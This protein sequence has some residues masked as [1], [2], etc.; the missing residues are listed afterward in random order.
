MRALAHIG[1][2]KVLEQAQ[3]PL[4]CIAGTSMGGLI[5]AAWATGWS[6]ERLEAEA[7]HLA[8][9]RRLATLADPALGQRGLLGG[10]KVTE[11]LA[12][13]LG[14]V[15]FEQTR[16]PLAVV[17]A[18]LNTGELVVIQEGLVREA[19]RATIALP[20]LL[21]PVERGERLLVDGA[22][23]MNL[24]AEMT[25][26]MGAE[27]VIAVDAATD[28]GSLDAFIEGLERWFVPG[29]IINTVAVLWRALMIMTHEIERRSL[30]E[31]APEL[32]LRPPIPPGVTV[33]TGLSQAAAV[34]AAGEQA[35]AEALPRL[36]ALAAAKRSADM[37]MP[38]EATRSTASSRSSATWRRSS[39]LR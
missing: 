34:I 38:I 23:L 36:E 13:M 12:Q 21:T 8:R 16:L 39:V 4:H 37:S 19:A 29:G 33:L 17:T 22:L 7:L 27:V 31:A 1:V 18:D 10:Q 25:R 28:Q 9:L 11:Y 20:G 6:A 24:P 30:E 2:L 32:I 26:S 5:A 35:A 3:V 15:T 14:D